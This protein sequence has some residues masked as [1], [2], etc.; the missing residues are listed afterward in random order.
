[1][2]RRPPSSKARGKAPA[3]SRSRPHSAPPL[4]SRAPAN[5][6]PA[7]VRDGARWIVGLHSC[8]ETLKV[9]PQKVREIWFR[10]GWASSQQLSE[11]QEVAA[12]A[13]I[14]V[15]EKSTGQLDIVGTGHQGVA[16]A[17]LETP[18]VDWPTLA[19]AESAV[20]LLLDGIE[21]PHNLGSILRTAWL[22][23]AAAIF[24]PND[25][26][27]G[28]T[29][30]VCKVAS[31]GAEHVPV[32]GVPNLGA[33]MEK[34]KQEGFWLY[35]LAEAGTRRPWDFQ[36]GKKTAWVV[37]NEAGGIRKATERACDELVR[38]PQVSSGSSYNAAIACAMALAETCRQFSKPD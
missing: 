25:R 5:Q 34:L 17:C 9:R 14:P 38:L 30:A 21:D 16:L 33:L 11:L 18:L 2:K 19:A 26:A 36:L 22:A 29:P 12:K 8:A 4:R 7:R 23:G 1:M 31:G 15:R 35:G 6:P 27:V 28:L 13:K 20:V 37:G 10:E 3:Q 24:I 32:E